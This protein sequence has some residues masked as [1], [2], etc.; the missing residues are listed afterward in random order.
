MGARLRSGCYLGRKSGLFLALLLA[1]LLLALLVLGILLGRCS[2]ALSQAW[3][4]PG[5]A[6]ATPPAANA[7]QGPP[8]R[9]PGPWDLARL[10]PHLAPLHY[11]LRLWPHLA[12]GLP[13]P[14]RSHSGQ[15]N[16]TVRCLRDT[17]AVLLHGEGLAY[18]EV[19]VWQD[20]GNGSGQPVPVEERW[21]APARQYLVL[22][23]R[24]NLSTG[25]HYT[26]RLAF[27]G[28]V[29]AGTHLHGLFLNT[30]RD[31]GQNRT[32]IASQLEPLD[33]RRVYPCFDEPAL[34]ATFNISIV[35]HPS[36]VALSNMPAID[37]S[38]YKDVND[39]TL[40]SLVNE[41]TSINWTVTT[42][43]MTPK[44]ST[45][46]T[47]F[48]ICQFD[49]VTTTERGKEIRIWAAKDSIQKG[50][51]DYALNITGPIF[52]FMEDLF[53]ISYP[54]PKTDLIA[55]P[56]MD[57]GAMENWGLMTFRDTSLLYNPKDK[58]TRWKRRV[59]QIVSHEIGHQWFGNL[60][61]MEWW[62]DLW[63]NEGFATYFEHLGAHH[64]DSSVS[65]DEDFSNSVL[66]PMLGLDTDLE[67]Q[68]LSVTHKK[69]EAAT[70]N[71]QFNLVTYLKGASIIRMLSS[72]LTETLFIK[73][74][75]SYLNVFSFSNAIQDDL[76]NHIQKVIDEQN[77]TS[78]PAKVKVIM[79][80]WTCQVGYPVLTVNFSTGNISQ[81]QYY[82]EKDKNSTN[83][84]WMIPISWI[85][86]GTVQPLLWLDKSSKIFPEM[87]ISDAERD[88]IILNVNMTGYYRINYG[89]T[90][91]RKLAKVLENDPKVIPVVNKLQLMSDAFS[92][93][94]SGYLEYGT[95][96]YFTKYLEKEDEIIVWNT[97]LP[98]LD[99]YSWHYIRDDYEL[100]PIL[101][102][103]LLPRILPVFHH[104]ASLLHE[105]VKMEPAIYIATND[106]EKI[107]E[108]VCRFGH[109]D[110]LNLIS[111]IF[112]RRMNR[113]D[114]E[115][116]VCY[117]TFV[118]CYG[119]QM[120]SDKEWEFLWEQ[121]KQ[122]GTELHEEYSILSALACTKEPWLLQR[123]LQSIINESS[124][125]F[126]YIRHAIEKVAKNEVGHRIAW[127]FITDNW[128]DLYNRSRS[129]ILRDF[130][131]SV[132][133]DVEVQ[134]IQGFLNN[135]LEPEQRI[136]ATEIVLQAK[137]AMDKANES[138]TKMIKWL[139]ENM[140]G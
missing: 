49:H 42:F 17:G 55:L 53:N 50:L 102:K 18:Q 61:T 67:G 112:T 95:A 25:A 8:E 140:N 2:R 21:E 125:E 86:N 114:N 33:A 54:L 52:S 92:M 30:Y 73:A 136:Q 58:N 85:R 118:C 62:N 19:S 111:E 121:Q 64:I 93:Q 10:P 65:L 94:W 60:V 123:L 71:R 26:L 22:Q 130:M 48:V 139:K 138:L 77:D 113:P 44:M 105:D 79:D 23:L 20:S 31:Q 129:G 4:E 28:K 51:A 99:T 96:L 29:H 15:V 124:I 76:W 34:K 37:V 68:S 89:Q 46:I 11:Q 108:T 127:K 120:G 119:V 43:A 35:H 70:I 131:G 9:P 12:P 13:H 135:T 103:Y 56:D 36:Y 101:K 3:R 134:M 115:G 83:N 57:A 97:V 82:S 75:H 91:F 104:Y 106:L 84:T 6:T 126:F 69:D 16:I 88:W 59:T 74:L 41:T 81:D 7:S 122:N 39:S 5:P 100:Y 90:H 137:S 128:A 80:T 40:S 24:R 98:Y 45:Y 132:R 63:L 117:S 27:T 72:F 38:E 47:A 87:K 109:R 107:F 110:C 14:P 116:H 133:T 1:A 78:L 32:L 66:F